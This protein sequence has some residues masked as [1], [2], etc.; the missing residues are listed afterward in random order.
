MTLQDLQERLD[1][2]ESIVVGNS[3]ARTPKLGKRVFVRTCAF[4]C[5]GMHLCMQMDFLKYFRKV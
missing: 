3:G 5:V 2:L 1:R 4:A